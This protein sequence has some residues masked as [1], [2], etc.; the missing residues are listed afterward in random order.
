MQDHTIVIY[1]TYSYVE[2][3]VNEPNQRQVISS[4]VPIASKRL[5]FAYHKTLEVEIEEQE[6]EIQDRLMYLMEAESQELTLTRV[7]VESEDVATREYYDTE[8]GEYFST[9]E[10]MLSINMRL[11][12]T[13]QVQEETA[14][15]FLTLLG[16][17][18]GF[19]DFIFMFVGPLVSY[20]VSEHITYR[21]LRS[22]FMM[23]RDGP[24]EDDQNS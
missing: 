3:E 5:D 8:T 13:K 10:S 2:S 17:L 7:Y 24:S 14:Y 21:I 11:A 4:L 20:I 16:D 1:A 22:L 6:F 19:I 15:D 23:N 9:K 12:N 18:G